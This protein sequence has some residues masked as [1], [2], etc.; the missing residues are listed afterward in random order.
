M[1]WHSILSVDLSLTEGLDIF[2]SPMFF[3][4]AIL[5]L[6]V[7]GGCYVWNRK[8]NNWDL[9]DIGLDFKNPISVKIKPNHD[10]ARVAHQIWTELQTRKAALP[11]D[12]ENDV[13][14]EV[15]DSWYALF[16]II[17]NLIKTI[18]AEHIRSNKDTEKLVNLLVDVL[19]LGLRPHLTRWQARF[20]A[21]MKNN[22][23]PSLSP[24]ELQK[25]FPEH[26]ELV[27][28]LKEVN[29]ELNKFSGSLYK[30]VHN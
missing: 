4:L 19:N 24:Q 1:N 2:I 10:T 17:R 11:F 26:A 3:L 27:K 12:E 8:Y 22:D 21:W 30:L 25:K 28:E 18:P 16:G 14:L 29:L 20:R 15:Y 9:V 13:I 7:V 23:D 6:A 5:I